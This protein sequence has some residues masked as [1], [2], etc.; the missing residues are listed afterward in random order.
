MATLKLQT[1]NKIT[2]INTTQDNMSKEKRNR[3]S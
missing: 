2:V 1:T 3:V